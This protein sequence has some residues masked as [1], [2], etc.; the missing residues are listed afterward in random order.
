[1]TIAVH[2]FERAHEPAVA[3]FNARMREARA[4]SAFLLPERAKP[5][6]RSGSVR[7]THHVA[8]D[9]HETVRGGIMLVEHPALVAGQTES[10]VNIQSP[11]SEG[12][13]DPAFTFVGPQLIKYA[14]RQSPHAFVVG[15]GGA[16]N[17]LPRLL[18]A[19]GWT[20]QT[21]P[22]YF[23]M[24]DAARCVRNIAPL[25]TTLAL[26]LGARIAAATGIATP[27]A[28]I[29]HRPSN[30]ARRAAADT[31]HAERHAVK[32]K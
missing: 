21:I 8:L 16:G 29:V 19:M 5:P 28:M 3:A 2:P 18:K 24:L 20:I 27:G 10:V 15:M 4:P 1:M 12:I 11:L 32:K 26:R 30:E 25:R 6:V 23:R 22:F 31:T 7:V 9:A 14:L 17:P 13:I